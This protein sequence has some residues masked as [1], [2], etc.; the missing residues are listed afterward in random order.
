M[1]AVIFGIQG[2]GKSTIVRKVMEKSSQADWEL[3]QW[4]ETAFDICIKEG[5]IRVGDY[6]ELQDCQIIYEDKR[7]N[8]A[9]ID[10]GKSEVIYV[11]DQEQ[12]KLAKDEIRHLNL[13]VQKRLQHAVANAYKLLI[14]GDGKTNY[15]IETHAAL[16][17]KQG[18]LPGLPKDFLESVDPDVYVIIEA[19]ADE[20]FVRRLLDKE[21]KREHDKTT[22]DVQTNLDTTRYFASTFAAV[23][24]SPLF[25]V[26]N[27]EKR[28]DDAAQEIV[29][30]LI[31]F[32]D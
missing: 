29:D 18:Y 28:A 24:H 15:I 31:K 1:I 30:V 10:N 2:V 21:R 9:I 4:G 13:K 17:T 8:V 23:S 22:K 32:L 14:N 16:K 25:I 20:I 7:T 19:N 12:I 5:I 6:S 26:E 3:L 27:K 11:K